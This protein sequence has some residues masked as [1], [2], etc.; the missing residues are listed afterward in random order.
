MIDTPSTVFEL[1]ATEYDEWFENH[2]EEFQAELNQIQQ[3]I[4]DVSFPSLE[5]G[6]GSGRFA[7]SLSI[8]YGIDPSR[9]LARMAQGRGIEVIQGRGEFLPLKG[10]TFS[11]VVMITVFCFLDDPIL[12]CKEIH[13]VLSDY[14]ILYIA[15]IERDGEIFKRYHNR[16]DKSRFLS[17]AW[18]YS[19]EEVATILSDSGFSPISSVCIKGFCIQSFRNGKG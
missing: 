9:S 4:R 8:P 6:V 13:R 18:F 12:T 17:Q 5:I 7:S 19:R 10:D 14:G 16:P 11:S 3:V 15:F 2:L 1:H